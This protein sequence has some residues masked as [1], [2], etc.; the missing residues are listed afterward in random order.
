M[1]LY[2]VMGY[3]RGLNSVVDG[4][5]RRVRDLSVFRGGETEIRDLASYIYQMMLCKKSS[6]NCLNRI[7]KPF[8]YCHKALEDYLPDLKQIPMVFIYGEL[9]WVSRAPADRLINGELV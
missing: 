9:D 5:K 4:F 7:F 2:R 8:L 6:E 1:E 3:P